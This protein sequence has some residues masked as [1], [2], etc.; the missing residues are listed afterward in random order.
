MIFENVIAMVGNTPVVKLEVTMGKQVQGYIKLEGYNPSGSVKDRAAIALIQA[1]MKTGELRPGKTILDASSG[2]FACSIAYFGHILGFPVTTVTGAKLTEDK[3]DYIQYFGA[4]RISY[5]NFTIDGNRYISQVIL[6]AD[7]EK[8]CFLDQLHNWENAN[9]HYRTTGP[10]I[11]KDLPDLAAVAFSLGSGG[12]MWGISKYLKEKKP[13]LKIIAVTAASG[14]KIPG[15]GAFVDGEH[16]TPFIDDF[17]KSNRCDYTAIVS[18]E[19]AVE[20][21]NNLN[22][23]GFYVGVQTG[24][25]L[26]GMLDGIKKLN[27]KGKVLVISGDAGWKNMQRLMKLG[28]KN[29][30]NSLVV[31]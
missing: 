29:K 9:V 20:R 30:D 31:K 28:Q 7:P 15:T 13:D 1:K 23:L 27:I 10:E 12:T 6:P 2:S 19:Q 22:K 17:F 18:E 4:Q 5:G 24:A 11:I 21:V 25:V 8:Y 14:S 16:V 26:Q 3:A